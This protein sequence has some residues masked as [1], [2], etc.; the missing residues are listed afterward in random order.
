[1]KPN[2]ADPLGSGFHLGTKRTLTHEN[3]SHLS[4]IQH[5]GRLNDG[6][7]SSIK[8]QVTGMKHHKR[9]T[10]ANLLG[11]RMVLP[12]NRHVRGEPHPGPP[13]HGRDRCPWR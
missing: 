1:M 10:T 6:F 9:K 7:P 13:R 12:R 5:L 8:A 4:V 2:I 3:K 11:D